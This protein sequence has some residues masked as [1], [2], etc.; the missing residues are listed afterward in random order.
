MAN[1]PKLKACPALS[2]ALDHLLKPEAEAMTNRELAR[3]IAGELFVNGNN[4]EADAMHLVKPRDC[5]SLAAGGTVT[6]AG[7][8]YLGGWSR[9]CA[10]DAIARILDS[11]LPPR[12]ETK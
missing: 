9:E 1:K 10:T 3:R 4:E 12:K 6:D 11:A 8:F 7:W 5:G 2:K